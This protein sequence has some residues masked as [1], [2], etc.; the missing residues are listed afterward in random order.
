MVFTKRAWVL[1]GSGGLVG[2]LG[3]SQPDFLWWVVPYDLLVALLMIVDALS[4]P[5]AEQFRVKRLH[6]HVLSLGASNRI[7]ILL[8]HDLSRAHCAIL[9]DEPP[10]DTHH[11][12]REFPIRL[13]PSEPV[14]VSYH[15]TPLY[16]GEARFEDMF[17]RVEGRLRLI[18]QTYRLPARASVPV[19][20]NL[21][22]MREYDLLRHRGALRQIGFRQFRIRGQGTEFESLRDYSPDDEFRRIDWKATARR[23]KPVVRDY[24]VE[25]SQNVILLLDCGRNMLAEVEETLKFDVVLN[26]ALMLAHVTTQMEDKVG[27]LAFADEVDQF[28]VPQRGR[29]QMRKLVDALHAV[30]P[31]MVESD[32]LYATTYLAKRWRKRSLMV[33]FTDLIDVDASRMLLQSVRTLQRTHLCVV[34]TV[35]DPKLHGWSRQSPSDADSLYRRAVATQ[36]LTDRLSAARQLERMGVHCI[37]AEPD[38][39][40]ANLVNYYLQVKARGGL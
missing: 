12:R 33:F 35:S 25:R 14:Q 2:L 20:P 30:Q 32:Y 4:L 24:Q 22:Q 1:I 27:A 9:R 21:L 37:D 10:R 31:R 13:V 3:L 28:V 39:L 19:Y 34:V 16:R 15:L 11:E 23:G 36:V 38:T 7:E 40:V 5:R 18:A 17:L 26:T 6:D 29:A 8:E